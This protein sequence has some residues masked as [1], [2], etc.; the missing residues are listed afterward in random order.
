MKKLLFI[1]ILVSCFNSYAAPIDTFPRAAISNGIIKA[2][3]LLPDRKTGYYRA[4][5]FDWSGV[6]ETL[7]YAGHSYFGQWFPKYDPLIHD[8]IKGPVEEFGAIGYE[9]AGVGERFIKIGVGALKKTADKPYSAF[10]LYPIEN[11]GKW[12]VK[13]RKDAVVFT[14]ELQDPSGYSYIYTKT[15][16]LIKGRPEMVL[17]HSLKNTGKKALETNV[18][19]HNFFVIDQQ[20]TGPEIKIKFPYELSGEGR[21]LG[22]IAELK[23]KEISYLRELQPREDMYIGSL[24]GFGNEAKDYDVRIENQ[25]SKAGVRITSDRPLFNMVFWASPT[26]S[27]PEPYIHIK[28]NPG[29]EFKWNIKYEFYQIP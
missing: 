21:G 25:K 20:M 16:R 24:K 2:S 14:Q 27:C 7:D 9:Q 1:S 29:E 3:L 12:K 17:E 8:A 23:G 18:Y 4:T 5:R 13:S 26:T 22:T 10:A 11:A 19:D 28:A 6:I 15:V